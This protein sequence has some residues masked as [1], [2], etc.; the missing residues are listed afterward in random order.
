[1]GK[2]AAKRVD[3]GRVEEEMK[4]EEGEGE[5]GGGRGGWMRGREKGNKP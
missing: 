1:M 4:G 5:E 3:W 2:F